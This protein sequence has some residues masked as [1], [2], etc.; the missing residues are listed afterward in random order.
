MK[1]TDGKGV[2]LIID[3][4]GQTHLGSHQLCYKRWPDRDSRHVI[5]RY[6]QRDQLAPILSKR[7]RIECTALGS[8]ELE[9]RQALRDEVVEEVFPRLADSAFKVFI[10]KVFSW[11]DVSTPYYTHRWP[12]KTLTTTRSAIRTSRWSVTKRRGIICLVD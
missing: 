10:E 3:P 5:W 7:L 2:D 1:A 4:V 12:V 6:R 8:R 11:K 9:Y